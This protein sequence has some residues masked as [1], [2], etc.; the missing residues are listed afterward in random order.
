MGEFLAYHR[1]R[2]HVQILQTSQFRTRH[3]SLKL[4]RPLTRET[5]TPLAVIPYLW[6]DGTTGLPSPL[7]ISRYCDEQFGALVRTSVGKRGPLQ[8]AEVYAQMPEESRADEAAGVFENIV[9][10]SL[11]LATDP[12]HVG[13]GFSPDFVKREK[14]LH[15]KRIASITDDKIA[16][17]MEQCTLHVC[18]GLPEGVPR[19][20][21]LEDLEDLTPESLWHLHEQLLSE[22][23]VYLYLVG[24]FQSPEKTGEEMLNLCEQHLPKQAGGRASGSPAGSLRA[25]PVRTD[26]SSEPEAITEH[27]AVQQGKLNL[28]FVTGVS[29]SDE[30]YPALLVANG[31]LGGFPHSKLFRNVREKESLAYYASSRLDGLSGIV[32]IQTGIEPGVVDKAR[33]IILQQVEDM[34]KGEVTQ[35]EL[36]LTQGAL[37]NQYR[38]VMDQPVSRLE[39]HF[40]GTLAG[41][42]RDVATLMQKMQDV[43][44]DDVVRASQKLTLDTVYFLGSKEVESNAN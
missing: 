16:Y 23:E 18:R 15:A 1:G 4:S 7:D 33:E 22:C 44:V 6:L 26:R 30:E 39:I 10:L 32:A 27:Q 37:A 42:D 21:Y 2:L 29:Y 13:G 43:T 9:K 24:D 5:V 11:E 34:K 25:I 14:S 3:L 36:A 20:G 35:D 31:I 40:S 28:G 8:L 41:I 17:A 19:L 12:L 38:Q